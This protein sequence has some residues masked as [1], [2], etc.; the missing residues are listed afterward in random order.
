VNDRHFNS[1]GRKDGRVFDPDH[2]GTHHN[3]FVR[4]ELKKRHIVTGYKDVPILIQTGVQCGLAAR[5]NQDSV[6]AEDFRTGLRCNPNRM[7]PFQGGHTPFKIDIIAPQLTLDYLRFIS[8]NLSYLLLK[9]LGSYY[10]SDGFS[11]AGKKPAGIPGIIQDRFAK[12][13]AGYGAAVDADA[14]DPPLP[15]NHDDA[16]PQFR[17]LY[18]GLLS[19]RP[20]SDAD[21]VVI[22]SWHK[23]SYP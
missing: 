16:F 17:C 22:V 23:N 7:Q 9:F 12:G 8:D 3:H 21:Q 13:L 4:Y 5:G 2:T 20:R 19:C 10:V 1:E 14:A 11:L 6:A 18:R 15:F